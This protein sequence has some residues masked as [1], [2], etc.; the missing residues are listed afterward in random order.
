MNHDGKVDMKDVAFVA[1]RFLVKQGDPLWDANA[2]IDHN[3]KIDLKDIAKV[4]SAFGG[5]C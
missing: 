5:H 3:E 4:A 2:D 1:R